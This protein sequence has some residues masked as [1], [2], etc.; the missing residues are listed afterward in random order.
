MRILSESDVRALI[1]CEAARGAVRDAFLALHRD[2]AVLPD[3]MHFDFLAAHGEAHVKGAWLGGANELWTV[4]AAT[5]FSG[6]PAAGLPIAGGLSLTLSAKTGL[7]QTLILDNG[8]LTE[9]RTGAAGAL[10]ADLLAV[11]NAGRVAVLG[12][13]NQVSFQLEALAL[14]REI[15]GVALWGRSPEHAEQRADLVRAELGLD[16]E[17]HTGV[18]GAVRDAEIIIT[19]TAARTPLLEPE[20]I[21]P[22]TH[23]TAMG[24]DMPAKQELA[25]KVLTRAD[26]VVVDELSQAATQGEVHHAAAAGAIELADVVTIGQLLSGEH[27]GRETDAQITVADLTGLGVQDAAVAGLVSAM[28]DQQELGTRLALEQGHVRVSE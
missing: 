4:K 3:V 16:V 27:P 21:A 7:P 25:V 9:L 8:W 22:G 10:A 2:E 1:D 26:L 19:A 6:N 15:H 23:I 24:S 17:V 13:G 12:S 20:W 5:G 28:A 11:P 14:V 18:E